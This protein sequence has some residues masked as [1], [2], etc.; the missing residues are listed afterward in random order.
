MGSEFQRHCHN[1]EEGESL[2]YTPFQMA[3]HL[4]VLEGHNNPAG[5]GLGSFCSQLGG[6]RSQSP[7]IP[8]PLPMLPAK[9]VFGAR[10][11]AL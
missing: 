10:P 6:D 8:F 7:S 4:I 5:T 3:D 2:P 11:L 9:V 1:V